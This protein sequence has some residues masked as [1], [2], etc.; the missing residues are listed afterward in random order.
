MT[1]LYL[2]KE[3]CVDADKAPF[4][5]VPCFRPIVPR[6]ISCSPFLFQH[7]EYLEN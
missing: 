7:I 2:H 1:V 6:T 5:E 4:A 3:A